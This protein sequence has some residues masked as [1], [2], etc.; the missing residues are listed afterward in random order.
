MALVMPLP[1]CKI[2]TVWARPTTTTGSQGGHCVRARHDSGHVLRA[3]AE[4]C[5]ALNKHI[6]DNLP[7]KLAGIVK[8]HA[9]L[10]VGS[11]LITVPGG[12]V[13]APIANIWTMYLR[14]N[15]EL[16]LTLPKPLSK[17]WPLEWQPTLPPAGQGG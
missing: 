7:E 10:A 16:K 14:T 15:K 17:R 2:S 8:L 1:E 13:A 4:L 9:G 12:D 6:D 5:K 3:A 11:A